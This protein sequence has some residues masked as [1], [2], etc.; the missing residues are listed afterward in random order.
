MKEAEMN[1]P[2]DPLLEQHQQQRLAQLSNRRPGGP[3]PPPRATTSAIVMPKKPG[4]RAKPARMAKMSALAI[5][6]TTTLGLTMA[7]AH[8]DGATQT[9]APLTLATT[10]AATTTPA[11]PVTPT[12]AA[13]VLDGTYAGVGDQNRWGT[14]QVQV[15]YAGGQVADVQILQYPDGERK[16]VRINQSALP[17]LVSEALSAQSAEVN[18]VSGA[19]YTS[20]SYRIS[21]QSAIDAARSASGVSN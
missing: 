11:T 17:R 15:V 3:L 10:P 21:L 9:I 6:A 13:G 19:T 2:T 12:T 4:R 14:V 18:T 1:T 16:S 5:S 7:F 20:K 8:D